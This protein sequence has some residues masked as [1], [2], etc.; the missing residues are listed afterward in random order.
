MAYRKRASRSYHKDGK[1]NL[2]VTFLIIIGLFWITFTWILPPFIEGL[3]KVTGF[4]KEH[5]EVET[6]VADNPSLAPPVLTIPY[7][8]TNSAKIDIH[9]FAASGSKV[10]IYLD[11]ELITSTQTNSDGS[12]T[13]RNVSLV[14]GTNNIYGKT[15]DENGNES[16][17]SK[18]IRLFYD[19]EKPPLQISTPG[20]GQTFSG[21]RKIHIA[22]N[23]EPSSNLTINEDQVILDTDGKFSKQISLNDGQSSFLIK[24]TDKA[25]NFTQIQRNVTFNP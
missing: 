19:N 2:L 21:E 23:T 1:S 7:E 3:G 8:A 13:A 15:E 22:G 25:G 12:F 10:K 4:F 20:D 16:L 24:S 18:I 6:S 14:L 11:D 5:K 17:A 9:G